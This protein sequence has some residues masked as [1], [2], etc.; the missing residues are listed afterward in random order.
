VQ[1]RCVGDRK[2]STRGFEGD[3]IY[4]FHKVLFKFLTAGPTY[5][6]LVFCIPAKPAIKQLKSPF[7]RLSFNVFERVHNLT[8]QWMVFD[9]GEN[10]FVGRLNDI[11]QLV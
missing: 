10:G 1:F 8:I 4:E 7:N 9:I 5:S 6:H 11:L 2:A 3:A